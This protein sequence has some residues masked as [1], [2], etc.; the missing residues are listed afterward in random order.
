MMKLLKILVLFFSFSFT[1]VF[2]ATDD[3]PIL[4]D[5]IGGWQIGILPYLNFGCY[6]SSPIYESGSM[7][8]IYKDNRSGMGD[9][10]LHLV[11][12]A[13]SS[14]KIGEFYEMK[15]VFE[16]FSDGWIGDAEV[17][18]YGDHKGIEFVANADFLVAFAEME[19]IRFL[20]KDREI[21]NLEL[22]GS[23]KAALS[24]FECQAMVDESG[25]TENVRMERGLDKPSLRDPFLD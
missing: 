25:V 24:L 22:Q 12:P 17:V 3:D 9:V 18:S 7:L 20:Y 21:L 8:S 15:V 2:S 13:W 10:Y 4:F 16:P 5:E 1:P 23:Y 14:L 11:N 19:S 6:T